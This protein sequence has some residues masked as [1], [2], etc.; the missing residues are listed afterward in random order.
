LAR[1][2]LDTHS[3]Q[4]S[5]RFD[6]LDR[7]TQ[8]IL[9]LMLRSPADITA[10]VSE[11]VR[12][13]IV[14]QTTTV[15]QI[16]SRVESSVEDSHRQTRQTVL[17]CI[18]EEI[19]KSSEKSQWRKNERE[20]EDIDAVQC[21]CAQR[22][23]HDV[24][25]ELLSSEPCEIT[26]G[27]EMLNVSGPAEFKL[28]RD[29]FFEIC[30]S[31]RYPAMTHRYEDVLKAYPET[32]EWA[33]HD[34]TE[35][36]LPWDNL[37]HWL[38]Q[39]H[40]IYWVNGKAGSG[41][42]TFMKHL[43]D[44]VRTRKCLK[45]WAGNA[46]ICVA[47]FFF[48]NSGSR[49]QKS[50]IGLLRSVLFQLFSQ[51]PNLI[52]LILPELW[53]KTYSKAVNQMYP[54]EDFSRFWSLQQLMVTLRRLINQE[55]IPLKI[56][57]IIDGLDEFDGDHEELANLFGE[58]TKAPHIKMCLSSRP[59]V[60][61][62]DY[63]GQCPNLRLQNLT[64]KD[65]ERYVM[66]KLSHNVAFLKLSTEEPEAAPALTQEIVEKADGVFLWVNIV[67]RSLLGGIR[68]RDELLDLWARLRS[69][70]RELEPLYS[71]LL[72]LI[73]PLYLPWVSKT[74][75][76][77]RNNHNL[78]Y[79]PFGK[80]SSARRGVVPLT[81]LT[82]F[83][84]IKEDLDATTMR[85][86]TWKWLN[87]KCED[88]RIRLTAR[89]AG[90]LEVSTMP[91][92]EDISDAPYIR[93]FHRTARDFLEMDT[94]WRGILMQTADTDFNPNVSMMKSCLLSLEYAIAN[95]YEYV[96]GL[97]RDFMIYSYHADSHYR[98]HGTRT[99]MLDRMASIMNIRSC[100]WLGAEFLPGTEGSRDTLKLATIYGL[101]GYISIK[102]A[103]SGQSPDKA[104]A[105]TLLHCLLPKDASS[106]AKLAMAP[107]RIDMISLLLDFGAD[108][109]EHGDYGLGSP[110]ENTLN[111]LRRSTPTTIASHDVES[112]K[113]TY[114]AIIEKLV[115]AGANTE[116]M[117]VDEY[118]GQSHSA[119]YIIKTCLSHHPLESAS[120]LQALQHAMQKS[121]R[122]GKR[123]RDEADMDHAESL[124]K[125]VQVHS[126]AR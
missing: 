92:T 95:D 89:C 23:R 45:T 62:E 34:P 70:P 87:S 29:V 102:L 39:S 68:N 108:P 115:V 28:R 31:L 117:F 111:F 10:G 12:N 27:I 52:P 76:I 53:A 116:T 60:V 63:F 98:S 7:Q 51:Q 105:T 24:R 71:H 124:A 35:E 9:Q 40:G 54:G 2:T 120:L 20:P 91:G 79:K 118:S 43:Y 26:A 13:Q 100:S 106:H 8:A 30:Q 112:Y 21:S 86:C 19:Q 113:M 81:L 73:E 123:Q 16:L 49:E 109:N 78:G 55:G 126:T 14:A 82:F 104:R 80:S 66:G 59:W 58:I 75:Q 6:N 110:W 41:K 44:D 22:S 83:L 94:H 74:L 125:R 103:R 18:K 99:I 17:E 101:R 72:G 47:T 11:E 5:T 37:T 90:L 64:F 48:W 15:G 32:F 96:S 25:R 65:I 84:A 4:A 67:V 61:F 38:E 3:L 46:P 33:F 1:E 50:Q 93:Y 88:V 56:F 69:M 42:S 77:L 85:Q 107:P 114:V 119:M 97:Q 122:N 57:F 36:Q 121:N